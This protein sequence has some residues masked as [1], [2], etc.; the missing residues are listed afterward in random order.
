MHKCMISV[1]A[2]RS[3]SILRAYVNYYIEQLRFECIHFTNSSKLESSKWL[4]YKNNVN[5]YTSHCF[6]AEANSDRP[7]AFVTFLT[8]ASF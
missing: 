1:T 4:F 3:V 2:E 5:D 7:S 6:N 8:T